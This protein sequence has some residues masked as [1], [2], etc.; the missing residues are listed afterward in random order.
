MSY[1]FFP[2][3]ASPDVVAWLEEELPRAREIA[4]RARERVDAL[5]ELEQIVATITDEYLEL[6]ELLNHGDA[7]Q[8]ERTQELVERATETIA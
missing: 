5:E 1:R 4:T 3:P 7:D 2:P 8:Q 6:N